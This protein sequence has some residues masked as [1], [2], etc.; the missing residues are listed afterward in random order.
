MSLN[1]SQKVIVLVT[2]LIL[3]AM[4]VYPPM[5][6]VL[7]VAGAKGTVGPV[8]GWVWENSVDLAERAGAK[9]AASALR[10]VEPSWGWLAI[11]GFVVVIVGSGAFV[12]AAR[13]ARKRQSVEPARTANPSTPANTSPRVRQEYETEPSKEKEEREEEDADRCTSGL[14]IPIENQD[15]PP[16]RTSSKSEYPA[17]VTCPDCDELLDLSPEKPV[18]ENRYGRRGV[19]CVCGAAFPRKR[20]VRATVTDYV[21][22]AVPIVGLILALLFLWAGQRA[23][24]RPMLIIAVTVY[25]LMYVLTKALSL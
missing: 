20:F 25:G 19:V 2:A 14:P 12:L 22:A 18:P 10:S 16:A 13:S 15:R 24:G 9:R 3:V 6:V 5:N 11:Q 4:C 23:R 1:H 7:A 8:W 17:Y 21:I